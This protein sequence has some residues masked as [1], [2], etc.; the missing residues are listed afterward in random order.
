MQADT[1]PETRPR[2][3]TTASTLSHASCDA[4]HRLSNSLFGP[5]HFCSTHDAHRISCCVNRSSPRG[6]RW[7]HARQPSCNLGPT[8]RP[9]RRR[10]SRHVARRRRMAGR[11][12]T[13]A[14]RTT[15]SILDG[16]QRGGRDNDAD[17][18][19]TVIPVIPGRR[20]HQGRCRW[21]R[22]PPAGRRRG[23]RRSRLRDGVAPGLRHARSPVPV[24]HGALLPLSGSLSSS[25]VTSSSCALPFLSVA[26][27]SRGVRRHQFQLRTAVP[28]ES[29]GHF[30]R[31]RSRG[32]PLCCR[33][34]SRAGLRGGHQVQ[35]RIAYLLRNRREMSRK[36]YTPL[37]RFGQY[38][39][40]SRNR[41]RASAL[42]PPPCASHQW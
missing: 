35:L 41:G 23:R 40:H 24:A 26:G 11:S 25:R 17:R 12:A 1:A 2:R 21:R 28:S 10:Y 6:F 9:E 39:D 29:P 8:R 18:D 42:P 38:G 14:S 32:F 37:R 30:G 20:A 33:S 15:R 34:P 16:L 4:D 19:V 22:S 5:R 31:G 7:A 36:R 13:K 3:A 27:V